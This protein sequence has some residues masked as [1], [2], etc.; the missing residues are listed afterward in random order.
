VRARACV[1]VHT[2]FRI[3]RGCVAIKMTQHRYANKDVLEEM[4]LWNVGKI[5]TL[6]GHGKLFELS[7]TLTTQVPRI[8]LVFELRAV[9]RGMLLKLFI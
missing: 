8:L 1:H 4:E 3:R 9:V 5:S 7:W 6:G 2:R